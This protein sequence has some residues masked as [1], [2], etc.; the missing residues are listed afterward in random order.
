MALVIGM[1]ACI[2]GLAVQ[3][4]A[5]SLGQHTSPPPS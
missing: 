4:G 3:G 5:E 2:E 1:I